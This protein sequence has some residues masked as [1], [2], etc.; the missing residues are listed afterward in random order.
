MLHIEKDTEK[1]NGAAIFLAK[2]GSMNITYDFQSTN[3]PEKQ[4]AEI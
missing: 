3:L 4:K 1:D 2:R